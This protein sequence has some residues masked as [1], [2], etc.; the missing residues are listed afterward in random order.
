MALGFP[1]K[2]GATL[3]KCMEDVHQD[4]CSCRAVRLAS[5]RLRPLQKQHSA[6]QTEDTS[7]GP[8]TMAFPG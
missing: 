2:Q 5:R 6:S 4:F 3:H 7:T 1:V 8:S